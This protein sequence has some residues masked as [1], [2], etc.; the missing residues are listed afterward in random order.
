MITTAIRQT[1]TVRLPN[2]WKRRDYQEPLW[3]YLRTGG[4]RAD[5]AWHRRAGKD[6]VSLHWTAI[7]SAKR[8]GTYWH[9]LPEAA[10]ARKAIWEAINP[11][12]GL[13]RIDEAFPRALR[14]STRDNDMLIR[15]KNGSTWQVVGSDN[16]NSLVGSPPVGV[17]FSE[18][19]LAKPD[20][21]TY[22]RPILAENGGW[23][24]FIWTPRGRNHATRSFEARERDPEWFTQRLPATET[25]VFSAEQLAK[26]RAELI[27]EAGSED[28][29]DA[30]YRQEYLVDFDAA[31]PG[32]YYGPQI[33]KAKDEG[34]IGRFPHDPALPVLTAWDIGV[35]DYTA[36]WFLQENGQ[37]VR[38]IDYFET[39]GEGPETI[40]PIL[41]AKGYRYGRHHLPHDVMV[42]EWGQGA[43]TRYQ[44]LMGLGVKPIR[45]GVAQ[46]PAERINAARRILP[47]VSFDAQACAVGL[48]RLRNYRKRWNAS[49]S[50]YTGPLHDE[51]SHGAD[52][53]GEFAVNCP[54]R[55][56]KP[57]EPTN[58][59][60]DLDI[61]RGR[62]RSDEEGSWKTL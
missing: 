9:M 6:D 8:V 16:F 62:R 45:V 13:R 22:M 25:G 58:N 54:I 3:R 7:A 35:D 24:V 56:P 5:V 61:W 15:F 48:D 59:P 47:I 29:G 40:V 14:E 37:K 4:L 26:E 17:V 41:E 11:H 23:A 42:R 39:S 34:R 30:K 60:T 44:T 43:R 10:Q 49:L 20:A 36:I 28:E 12:T 21:W 57:P 55:P 2:G 32:S 19:S 27:A 18:W 33:A 31:V 51:N 1:L 53:F 46:D 50:T 38:A 52:A